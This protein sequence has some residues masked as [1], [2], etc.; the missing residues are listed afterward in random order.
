ML[1]TICA[2]AGFLLTFLFGVFTVYI[3]VIRKNKYQ[4]T[5][6]EKECIPLYQSI[7]RNLDKIEIQY[8][9]KP[10]SKETVL[11]KSSIVNTGIYDIDGATVHD[12]LV[13]VFP[14]KIDLLEVEVSERPENSKVEVTAIDSN[15]I[16]IKWDLLKASESFS[17]DYLLRLDKIDEQ[18]DEIRLFNELMNK[19]YHSISFRFRITNLGAIKKECLHE[20]PREKY[21][22]RPLYP[23]IVGMVIGLALAIYGFMP[24]HR[25]THYLIKEKDRGIMEVVIIPS[26]QNTV[27]IVGVGNDYRSEQKIDTLEEVVI[28]IATNKKAMLTFVIMGFSYFVVFSILFLFFY[29]KF[30]KRKK[31]VR[32]IS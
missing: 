15:R 24:I 22:K 17:L 12:P 14:E 20:M 5:Y 29:K 26:S 6:L 7:D 10:I 19:I 25:E 21:L 23:S 30:L 2:I 3:Y 13:M 31:L 18:H 32:F 28:K 1:E 27:K 16:K 4:I 9:G 11:I 8:N